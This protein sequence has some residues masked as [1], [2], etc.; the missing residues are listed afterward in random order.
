M[1]VFRSFVIWEALKLTPIS[2]M[3]TG[4]KN[5]LVLRQKLYLTVKQETTKTTGV[6]R[7]LPVWL[8]V[9]FVF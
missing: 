3:Q 6:I 5:K 8:R 9:V 4:K 2:S 7:C 1:E